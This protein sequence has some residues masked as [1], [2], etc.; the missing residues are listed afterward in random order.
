MRAS[1]DSA[2]FTMARARLAFDPE[3]G[4]AREPRLV[5]DARLLGALHA[6]LEARLGVH[7]A[8]DTLLHLGFLHGLRD[9]LRVVRGGWSGTTPAA[10]PAAPLL[11]MRLEPRA[12]G[13]LPAL[14][15]RGSWPERN[16]AAARLAQLGGATEPSCHLSAGYTSGWLS[17]LLGADLLAAEE[18]CAA[19]GGSSCRFVA[20]EPGEWQARGQLAVAARAR[21][22]PFAE[23][24]ALVERDL[25]SGPAPAGPAER[26]DAAAPVVHVWGPVMVLPFCGPDE[27]LQAVEL[28]GRDPAAREVSVVVV[29]LTG[30]VIDEGFGALALEQTLDVIEAWGAEPVLAGVSPLSERVVAELE[31]AHLVVRKD[32]PQAI[33]AAF[34]I[35]Q[36]QQRLV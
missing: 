19:C 9:A 22:L 24:R 26:F 31:R 11:P 14:E 10:P 8:A 4:L 16:E 20:R 27:S 7:E 12:A 5:V 17:G 28:I 29:D 36:A 21:A 15:L 33:A 3:D 35:A 23:L 13:G 25:G 6:E 1:E 2:D 18:E 34:V 32:L 30:A